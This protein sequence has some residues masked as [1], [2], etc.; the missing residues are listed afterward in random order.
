MFGTRARA[1]LVALVA[2]AGPAGQRRTGRRGDNPAATALAPRSHLPPAAADPP[3]PPHTRLLKGNI[4]TDD[5]GVDDFGNLYNQYK[6][7]SVGTWS[8]YDEAKA[9]PY[10]I[11]DPLVLSDGTRVTD[12]ATWW[13]RRRPEILAAFSTEVYGRIPAPTPAVTWTVASDTAAGG[14][15]TKTIVGRIDNST[16]PAAS[17]EIDLTLSLPTGAAG[18]V[19]VM[20]V[21]SGGGGARRPAARPPGPTAARPA[22]VRPS[23]PAPM[24]QVLARGWG[25][26]VFSTG[27]V[28]ADSESGLNRGIIGLMNQGRPRS[29]PAAGAP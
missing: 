26:A 23:G 27:S 13:S 22:P 9:D 11:P 3:R 10:P 8:N 6:R 14:V 18:P 24:E 2:L 19:P 16:F 15:R 12:A 5:A 25:Y 1:G 21:V 28:Q 4:W 29:D 20:V 7:S 17:P